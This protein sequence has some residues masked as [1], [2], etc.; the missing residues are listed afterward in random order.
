MNK[1]T[2]GIGFTLLC[3]FATGRV[4][5]VPAHRVSLMK[6]YEKFLVRSLANCSTCHQPQRADLIPTSLTN[7]PHN[8]FGKRLM[9]L[10][11][12]LSKQGKK[13]DLTLR[14]QKVAK[15][16]TDGDGVANEDEI[17]L[18]H[19][20]GEPKDTPSPE[21]LRKL[22]QKRAEF[23]KFLSS[24][25]WQP[26]EP[27]R[28]PQVPLTPK[29]QSAE[30]RNPIDTFVLAELNAH[31]L[32][33][34]PTASKAILLRRLSMDI[35]GLTPTPEEIRAFENDNSPNAYEKV[36]DRLLASPQ[37][38]ERWGRHWMD[39]WRYSDWAGWA[40]GGQIRDSK[41]HI[42]RWRDWIIDALNADKGYNRMVLEM[43]AADEFVPEDTNA[44]RATGFLVRNFKLLSREQWMEDVVA[45]TSRAFMGITLH[46]AKCHDH[47]YD[48]IS[49]KEYYRFRAIFEPHQVR[50]DRIPGEPNPDKDGLPRAYDADTKAI[51]YFYPRGDERNPDKNQPMQPGVPN[52]MGGTYLAS[53]VSLPRNAALPDRRTFVVQESFAEAKNNLDAAFKALQNAKPERKRLATLEYDLAT[54]KWE[55]LRLA[56]EVEALEDSKQKNTPAWEAKAKELVGLQRKQAQRAALQKLESA[57]VLQAEIKEERKTTTD[58]AA[59]AKIETRNKAAQTQEAEAKKQLEEAE[60]ALKTPLTTV[61][62]PR[63]AL[64]FPAESSGRRLALARWLTNPQHPLTARVA[65]N[66]IWARHFGTGLIPSTSDF[67]RN[68]RKPSHPLLLDWL[69]S[70]LVRQN[71]SMKQIH[72]LILTSQ[73]YRRA[74]TPDTANLKKDP[75]NTYL[76]RYPSRRVE[77]EIVRDNILWVS[78]QLDKTMGGADID[79]NLGLT[80]RRRS[81]YLRHAAEKQSEFLQVFDGPSVTECYERKQSVMPQ[82]ALALANSSLALEM[83]RTLTRRMSKSDTKT[84]VQDAFLQVLSRPATAK[85]MALCIQFLT[86]Q[87]QRLQKMTAGAKLTAD[88][89]ANDATRP[90]E[91]VA[92]RAR[93]N[94][95]HVL[96]NHNDFVTVR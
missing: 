51:T 48:P 53:S 40:D 59:L 57:S 64:S 94:L 4:Q 39:V 60:K 72:R 58:K 49:Q 68:G 62:Q 11:A 92:L 54:G 47:M 2:V 20:P 56:L 52:V 1:Q 91:S 84:F 28:R 69:A 63:S 86:D 85:E 80:S 31:N 29:A 79:H 5:A 23:Q 16:D 67:G 78:G 26:F 42:W 32:K 27:V 44:L 25:R 75:D 89:S 41:P 14:L 81:V 9:A 8:A 50:T 93:E 73:T 36:V 71:W 46:C 43:L 88:T 96:L 22:P 6:H 38:G 33:P 95:I 35:I 34:R 55:V 82:Q 77:A 21:E 18:G 45:H 17:L 90:A 3:L 76:W 83:G 65:V 74:S 37:Y 13:I 70:E 12:E 61:Y 10:G 87:E 7:F 15:E 24:Y 30:V 66:H 19:S